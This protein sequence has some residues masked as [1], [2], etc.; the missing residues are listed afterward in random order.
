MKKYL[1]KNIVVFGYYGA[2]YADYNGV[3]G[4]FALHRIPCRNKKQAYIIARFNV[5]FLNE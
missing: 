2:Y 3:Y 4:R 1:Y 5:D